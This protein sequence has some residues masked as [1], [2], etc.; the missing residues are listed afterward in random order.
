MLFTVLA[1]GACSPAPHG[2]APRA[3]PTIVSLNPCTDAI[4]ADVAEPS[5][6]LALS[7]Y[8]RDPA[9]SSMD[10]TVARRFAATSGTVEELLALRPDI[11]VS[12]NFLSPATTSAMSNLGLRLEQLPIASTVPES[13]AQVRKLAL[14]TGHPERGELLVRRIELALADAAPPPGTRAVSAVVWQ[15]GGMVPGDNTLIAD[16]LRRTGFSV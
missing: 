16:L 15:S 6:I 9:S 10:V 8:S 4:L 5:Q 7:A 11:V 3:H 13:L 12:S 2:V 14:L 1:L